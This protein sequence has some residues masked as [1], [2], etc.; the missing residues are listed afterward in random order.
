MVIVAV[1]VEEEE[2][3]GTLGGGGKAGGKSGVIMAGI[4]AELPFGGSKGDPPPPFDKT[5]GGG[6]G[7]LLVV[8]VCSAEI[9]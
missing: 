8:E 6:L 7:R 2:D 3:N 5:Q 1:V 4:K 9:H